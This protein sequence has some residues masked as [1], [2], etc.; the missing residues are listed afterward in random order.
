[1]DLDVAANVATTELAGVD[2]V[3]NHCVVIDHCAAFVAGG[4]TT[5]TIFVEQETTFVRGGLCCCRAGR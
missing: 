3:N 4:V 5:V 1:M 2:T